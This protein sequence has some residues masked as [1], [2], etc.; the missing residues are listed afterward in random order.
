M[1]E[2]FLLM[3]TGQRVL[4]G[5]PAV[6]P[7][8]ISK[9]RWHLENQQEKVKNPYNWILIP[10][11]ATCSYYTISFS[12]LPANFLLPFLQKLIFKPKPPPTLSTLSFGT[13]V[14]NRDFSE[15][16]EFF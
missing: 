4:I 13:A 5:S 12:F 11:S 8:C 3:R 15:I 9:T 6:S 1:H 14:I 7:N 16:R 10:A 2:L